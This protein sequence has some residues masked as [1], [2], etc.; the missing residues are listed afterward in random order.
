M[1]NLFALRRVDQDYVGIR[2]ADDEGYEED[3]ASI[4]RRRDGSLDVNFGDRLTHHT[5]G[6]TLDG[7]EAEPFALMFLEAVRMLGDA[8]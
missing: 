1:S 7:A 8:K 6:V 5:H 3:V 2:L 4:A